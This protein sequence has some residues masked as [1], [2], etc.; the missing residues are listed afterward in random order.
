MEPQV[1]V[2]P[3]E[4]A[5]DRAFVWI[6]VYRLACRFAPLK[7]VVEEVLV[8]GTG[9]GRSVVGAGHLHGSVR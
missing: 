1:S 2:A 4:A 9:A 6:G 7:H 3:R 8:L 5:C